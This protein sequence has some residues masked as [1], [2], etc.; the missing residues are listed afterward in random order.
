ML[1]VADASPLIG[2]VKIGHADVL[3]G[4]Y[5]TVVIPP[6]VAAELASPRRPADVRAFA[7]KPPPWL[8]VRAPSRVDPID[9]LDPGELEAI[10]LAR[11]LK[12][13]LLLIDEAKGRAAAVALGI[14]TARTAAVL[15]DAANAGVLPDLKAAFDKLRATNFRVPGRVLD[16]LLARHLASRPSER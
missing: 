4:V 7:A 8:E 10:N 15:F 14:L 1:V 2:L 5:G 11:E 16:E 9:D 12:A 13:D 6:R 3:A